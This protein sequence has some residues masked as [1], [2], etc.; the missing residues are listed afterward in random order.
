MNNPK[1]KNQSQVKTSTGSTTYTIDEDGVIITENKVK[2]TYVADSKEQFY[3]GYVKM[4]AVFM[5]LSA[6]AIKTFSYLLMNYNA[7][8]QIGINKGIKKKIAEQM[9]IQSVGTINNSITELI[10]PH[11]KNDPTLL[12]RVPNER[13]TYIINPRYAFKGSTSN[14]NKSLCAVTELM[15]ANNI[16]V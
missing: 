14:R 11:G 3:I 13:G 15:F 7:G 10:T 1:F 6:P 4:L 5:D 2:R 12:L 8:I 9:G 16:S